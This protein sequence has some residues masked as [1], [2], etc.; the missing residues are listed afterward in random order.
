[1]NEKS[2]FQLQGGCYVMHPG[3]L[4]M[5]QTGNLRWS[6]VIGKAEGARK[7]AQFYIVPVRGEHPPVIHAENCEAVI[8][9]LRGDCKITISGRA[10]TARAGSGIH[11]RRGEAFSVANETGADAALLLTFCPG[12]DHLSL[13][14][15]MPDNFDDNFP[16]RCF[17][18]DESRRQA[19]GDR[20]YK[21]LLGP[22][23]GSAEVTQFIGMI[24]WSKAPEHFHTYEEAICILSGCGEMWAGD[25]HAPVRP[26][27]VIFL[28][29]KQ[30]HCL[31]CRVEEG[32]ELVGVFYPAGSPAVNYKTSG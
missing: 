18:A 27:S 9:V 24:P 2:R 22:Q 30:P 10:F 13:S 21:L 3:R 29:R 17:N 8:F 12:Q 16:N 11:V 25:S 14:D 6:R 4:E 28:P 5:Q 1:M 7:L 23:T 26:G 15:A 32:M 20:Y 31:E 19:T